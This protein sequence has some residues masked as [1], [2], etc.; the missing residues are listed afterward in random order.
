MNELVKTEKAIE[1]DWEVWEPKE[2][3]SYF[4]SRDFVNDLRSL[5]SMGARRPM[6]PIEMAHGFI[7]R[8][9]EVPVEGVQFYL[10]T[11]GLNQNAAKQVAQKVF[12]KFLIP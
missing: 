4:K 5:F 7:V 9:P 10:E 11:Q 2:N 1:A 3:A 8:N 12:Q 6:N